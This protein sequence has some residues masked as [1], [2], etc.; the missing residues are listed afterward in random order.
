MLHVVNEFVS[1]SVKKL[2]D[3][4]S[5]RIGKSDKSIEYIGVL[6]QPDEKASTLLLQE[7]LRN[8]GRDASEDDMKKLYDEFNWM[9]C[10]DIH[11]RP[12]T[13]EQFVGNMKIML[14]SNPDKKYG[15]SC[16][17]ASEELKLDPN[18]KELIVI[19]RKLAYL[20]D[21][22]DDYRRKGVFFAQKM[23]EELGRRTKLTL[24]ET[25]YLTEKEILDFL[26]YS[27]MPRKEIV[28]QRQTGFLVFFDDNHNIVCM[29]GND[30][31]FKLKELGILENQKQDIMIK[32]TPASRGYA[33]GRVSIVKGVGDLQKV[34]RGDILVAVTTHPDFVPAM[35]KAIA[36]VTDEGGLS[37]HAAIV[38]REF[39]IPC[40]VGTKNATHVLNDGDVVSVDANKGIVTIDSN[41]S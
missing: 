22:R 11:N 26:D 40:I 3:D 8:L 13:Y 31:F 38:S 36:V 27:K 20:K 29:E 39:G 1:E 23:F 32:G 30:M 12:W 34:N 7:K 24:E 2:V 9:A 6:I 18:E 21:A 25:S 37:S 35:K 28:V 15:V 14:S 17:Q 41:K 10:L 33:K 4:K 16:D 19:A 5:Q